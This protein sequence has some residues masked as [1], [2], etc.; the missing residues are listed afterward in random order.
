L[1][2]SFD[3]LGTRRNSVSSA[4]EV[5]SLPLDSA[6]SGPFPPLIRKIIAKPRAQEDERHHC[7]EGDFG[8]GED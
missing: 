5:S 2:P 6:R 7:K 1:H 4:N 3:K 8:Y